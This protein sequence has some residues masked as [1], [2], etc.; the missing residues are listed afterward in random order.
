MKHNVRKLK[1]FVG[2]KLQCHNKSKLENGRHGEN[3]YF[4]II[5]RHTVSEIW[6]LV[7]EPH[8]QAC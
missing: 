1:E 6:R 8:V 2:T 4:A 7:T 5:P 3:R